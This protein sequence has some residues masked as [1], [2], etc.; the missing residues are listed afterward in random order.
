[1]S[2]FWSNSDKISVDTT[3]HKKEDG[4][5]RKDSA[6]DSQIVPVQARASEE[7]GADNIFADPDVAAHYALVYEKSQ[8]ECRHVFDPHLQWSRKE[9]KKLVRKLDWH[10]C[11]WAVSQTS[12]PPWKSSSHYSSVLPVHHVFCTTSGSRKP[13]SGRF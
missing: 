8:Y 2:V 6:V 13:R 12:L 1:M 3:R 5:I 9:E 10:V 7:G 11:T 4:N